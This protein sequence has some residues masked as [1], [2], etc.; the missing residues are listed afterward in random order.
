MACLLAAAEAA[1]APWRLRPIDAFST[2]LFGSPATR[3]QWL[4]S[5][6]RLKQPLHKMFDAP[7]N[8][9]VYSVGAD[10]Q[11]YTIYTQCDHCGIYDRDPAWCSLCQRLKDT[12]RTA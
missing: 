6:T 2:T 7:Y 4:L 3:P 8:C 12:K 11:T 10:V 5:P 1:L 9:A